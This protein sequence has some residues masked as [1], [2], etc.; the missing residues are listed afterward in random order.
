M[1]RLGLSF[2]I[3]EGARTAEEIV[4]SAIIA[5]EE[6]FYSVFVPEHYYDREA[7]SIIGAIA[8]TTKKIKIGTGVI[9]PFTRYPSLIAMS[10]ATIDELSRGRAILG[11]GSGGVIGSLQH[12]I[13][14]EIVGFEY[15]HPLEHL[16]EII[17]VMRK[18]LNGENVTYNGKFYKLNNVKLNLSTVQQ[19]IPIYLG[20]QG[21]KMMKL[22]AQLC[23]G[24]IITLCA[25][26]P[27]IKNVRNI[28]E[29]HK[30]EAKTFDYA[31]RIVV[32]FDEDKNKAIRR[33]KPLVARVLIHPGAK[34]LIESSDLKIDMGK[35][36]NAIKA[37]NMNTINEIISDDIVQETTA[38]GNLTDIRAR[39][40]EY[41]SAGITHPLIVPI[42]KNFFEIIRKLKMV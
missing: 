17:E 39:M 7:T 8:Y 33:A 31:A 21:L 30:S 12:G 3:G 34:P 41:I 20:Q 42:G 29:S 2:V 6:G 24:V 32:S 10:I 26:I 15:S 9:N 36:I 18:L 16:K 23:D 40:D 35:L 1:I 11:L 28:I 5:E 38:S 27:Y 19:K 25:T 4:K 22:A 37:D 13:P 14:S